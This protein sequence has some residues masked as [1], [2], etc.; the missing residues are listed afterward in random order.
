MPLSTRSQA[1]RQL[2]DHPLNY[3]YDQESNLTPRLRRLNMELGVQ[4]ALDMVSDPSAV[5]LLAATLGALSKRK[6]LLASFF[7]A[8]CAL[9]R[10][11]ATR[12]EAPGSRSRTLSKR[13]ELEFERLAAKA[14]RGDYGKLEVIAFK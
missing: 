10:S 7:A 14:Q 5:L 3:R 6:Y 12:P 2:E 11:G 9:K 8:A 4:R 1:A 13:K